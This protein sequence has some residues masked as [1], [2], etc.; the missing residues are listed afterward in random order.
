MMI[1]L[2][3]LFL[4]NSIFVALGNETFQRLHSSLVVISRATATA[5]APLWVVIAA[6]NLRHDG[7]QLDGQLLGQGEAVVR[8]ALRRLV[9]VQ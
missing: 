9:A 1:K 3:G 7:C 5:S 6:I 4:R 8:N 2:L